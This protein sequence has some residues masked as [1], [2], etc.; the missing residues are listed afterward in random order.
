MAKIYSSHVIKIV[1]H[2]IHEYNDF[3]KLCALNYS[4]GATPE[5]ATVFH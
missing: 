2:L 4:Q 3:S 1:S 5:I